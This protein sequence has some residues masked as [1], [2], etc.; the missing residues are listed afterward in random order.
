MV[1][2]LKFHPRWVLACGL[3][4]SGAAYSFP[5]DIDMIDGRGFKAFEWK[6]LPPI[7]EGAVQRPTGGIPRAQANGAYQNDHIAPI[8]RMAPST[9]GMNNP[10]AVDKATLK[11]GAKLFRV[12]CAPCHGQD[13]AGGG[14]VTHNDPAKGVNRV[15]IPAPMLSGDGAVTAVR[16][17]GYLYGTIR[18]GGSLMPKY[19]TSLTDRE[20]WAIVAYMRT[21]GG[22][23]V[24]NTVPLGAAV[25]PEP[26]ADGLPVA[27]ALDSAVPS[28]GAPR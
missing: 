27:P 23:A 24:T 18:N 12:S 3:L 25:T 15:P 10:Y 2:K 28:E 8:D 19:G 14:P 5:W 16:S 1:E 22:G 6:M 4:V 11:D 13:G 17:D 26:S 9:D 21:L 7:P 20:R